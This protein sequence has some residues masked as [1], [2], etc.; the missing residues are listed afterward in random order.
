MII[1]K[2]TQQLLMAVIVFATILFAGGAKANVLK[3]KDIEMYMLSFAYLEACQDTFND[4]HFV[5]ITPYALFIDSTVSIV[6]NDR[7]R[8]FWNS[9]YKKAYDDIK[10]QLKEQNKD[11]ARSQCIETDNNIMKVLVKILSSSS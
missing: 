2:A 7:Q 3:D 9:N 5:S 10:S 6:I 11:I 1:S 4:Y 8:N